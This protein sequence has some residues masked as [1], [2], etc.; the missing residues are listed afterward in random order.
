MQCYN[1]L[2]TVFKLLNL[3]LSFVLLS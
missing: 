3:V 1:D 2:V